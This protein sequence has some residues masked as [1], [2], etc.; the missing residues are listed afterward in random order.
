MKLLPIALVVVVVAAM[1]AIHETEGFK[2]AAFNVQVFG[3]TK[4]KK[5]EVMAVLVDV[6]TKQL[7]S[8]YCIWLFT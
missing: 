6:R 3:Q 8:C 2:I 1:V 5:P 4:S 7:I